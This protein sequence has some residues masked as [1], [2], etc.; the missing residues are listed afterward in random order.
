VTDVQPAP[1][2]PAGAPRPAVGFSIDVPDDWV[3][4]DLDPDTW[5]GWVDAFLDRRMAARPQAQRER[6][7][8]R[9]A[10]VDL[11]QRLHDE[12]V[13]LAA[14]LA[15]EADGHLVSASATLAWRQPDLAGDPL[16]LEGLGHLYLLAPAGPGED[17]AARRVELIEL[18]AG[19]GV[20]VATREL[21]ALPTGEAPEARVTQY[22][23]PVLDTGWLA[24]IT[25][26]TGNAELA[27]AV[28]GVADAMA[29][30]LRFP[31]RYPTGDSQAAR[32][33]QPD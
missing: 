21:V 19:G 24:V 25:T 33:L 16:L 28:E 14:V 32:R 27:P 22:L 4:L 5:G 7:P 8:T 10:L 26:T 3:V 13:F 9:D 23:V 15:G 18:P 6:A 31:E 30:S 2:F 20:K 11:L 29:A 1:G 17:L 12:E